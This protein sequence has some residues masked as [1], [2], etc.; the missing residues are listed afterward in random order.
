VGERE[1]EKTNRAGRREK[2]AKNMN[3]GEKSEIFRKVM[4]SEEFD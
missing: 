1:R 3:V 4:F 2:Q